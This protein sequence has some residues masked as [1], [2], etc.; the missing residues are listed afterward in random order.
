MVSHLKTGN[1]YPASLHMSLMSKGF[2]K[3][4]GRIRTSQRDLDSEYEYIDLRALQLVRAVKHGEEVQKA[5]CSP[6]FSETKLPYHHPK[7]RKS[8]T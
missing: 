8:L 1:T 4:Y 6:S 5:F 2:S 7:Q 3:N